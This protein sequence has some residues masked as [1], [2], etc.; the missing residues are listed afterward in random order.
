M[1][2]SPNEKVL[3]QGTR[4]LKSLINLI[5]LS[6]LIFALGLRLD[7]VVQ[8]PKLALIFKVVPALLLLE[9]FRRKFNDRYTLTNQK[10]IQE[11]GLLSFKYKMVSLRLDD[12]R[13]VKTSQ[14]LLG[15]LL[16]FGTISA[17][18]AAIAAEEIVFIGVSAPIEVAKRIRE[19]MPAS[20]QEFRE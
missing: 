8:N 5:L 4:S 6:F 3:W 20:K 16:D 15:R 13:E 19:R 18:T 12:L 2:L 7:F 14:S 1:I 10:L 17:G 11:S 9:A